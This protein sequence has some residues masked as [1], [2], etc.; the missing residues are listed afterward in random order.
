MHVKVDLDRCQDHGLCAIAA[1]VVFQ[2]DAD[3]KL[4]YEGDPDDSQLDYVEEA[5]DGCPVAAILIGE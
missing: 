4:V 5:A 3:G 1:P 2:M